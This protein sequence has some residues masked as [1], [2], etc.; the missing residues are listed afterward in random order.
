M[1]G[2]SAGT[3]CRLQSHP[4]PYPSA[5]RTTDYSGSRASS[6]VADGALSTPMC[7]APVRCLAVDRAG[8][9]REDDIPLRGPVG[10]T[11]RIRSRRHRR[12]PRAHGL[13]RGSSTD[14]Q[15]R[16]RHHPRLTTSRH[17]R[18]EHRTAHLRGCFRSFLRGRPG[19]R[20]LR[21]DATHAPAPRRRS[22]CQSGTA[23]H[24]CLRNAP[25]SADPR[26]RNTSTGPR[27]IQKTRP[28]LP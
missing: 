5:Q 27:P 17:R 11:A 16:D 22:S 25:R 28:V 19:P 9:G 15:S 26:L 14:Q 2:S 1:S 12:P 21:Q 3:L 20:F 18:A 7:E 4:G 24:R 6:L 8:P 10:R 23:S 13:S